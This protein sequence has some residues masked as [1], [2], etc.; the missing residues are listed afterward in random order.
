MSYEIKTEKNKAVITLTIPKDDVEEG[1]KKA[2]K[3]MAKEA[4]IPGFRPGKA[5]YEVIVKRFGEMAILEAAAEDLIRSAFIEALLAENL[6]TVGSPH[7]NPEKFAPGN[8]LVVHVEVAL[9]PKLL[10]LADIDKLSV[11]RKDT[12]PSK[13]AIDQAK[14]DLARMQTKEVRAE[15][16]AKLKKGDKAVVNLTMKKDGVV[17][18][19]GEGQDHGIYT[20]EPHYI[21]GLVD[22]LIGCEEGQTCEFSLPFPKDHYQKH[23]AGQDVDFEIVINEI[24]HLEAPEM[25]DTFAKGLGLKDAKELDAKLVENLQAE[26]EQEERLRL[27][28]EVLDLVA[29]KSSFDEIPDLLVNQEIDKMVHELEHQVRERGMEFDKYLKDIGKS[30]PEL[31]L[32]FT[33]T[34]LK[35]IQVSIV[36][37]ELT[38]TE[39]IKVDEKQVDAELDKIAERYTDAEQKKRV[40]EPQFREYIASQMQNRAVIDWLKEKIVK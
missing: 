21:E 18:E 13:E 15:K 34:A 27:D 22:K 30:L 23:L 28:K 29:D 11:E 8:D 19:G 38:E 26:N 9:Y 32:D 16:G 40:Y 35:R 1:M 36:L 33:P 2:A 3:E 31:K 24:F 17:L 5:S 20:N 12:K 39:D 10:K 25:D 6:A 14:K 37:R 7:F 4:K